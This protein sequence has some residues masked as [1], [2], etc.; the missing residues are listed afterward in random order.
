MSVLGA[1]PGRNHSSQRPD[2][3]EKMVVDILHDEYRTKADCLGVAC[4]GNEGPA[5]LGGVRGL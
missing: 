1:P 3:E 4:I 5:T 2:P